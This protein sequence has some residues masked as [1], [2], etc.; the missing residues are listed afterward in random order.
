[1]AEVM[2]AENT[3]V[4]PGEHMSRYR[5]VAYGEQLARH[6]RQRPDRPA[7]SFGDRTLTYAELDTRVNRLCRTLG[8]LGVGPGDRVAVLMRNRPEVVESYF[9]AMR[10][11]AITVPVN[12]R[13]TAAEVRYILSDSGA[14]VLVADGEAA[15]VAHACLSGA[16]GEPGADLT[17][18][19]LAGGRPP[20]V[21]PVAVGYEEALD[22]DGSPVHVPVGDHDPAFIMYTS[23]TTGRPKGA[24]LTHLNLMMNSLNCLLVQGVTDDTEVY[25]SG[26]PL[27]HIGGLNGILIYMTVGGRSIVTASGDFSAAEA[28][29]EMARERVTACY[30]VPTQ[31]KEICRLP[32]IGGRDL[33]LRRISWGASVAPPAVLEAM[34]RTFPGIPNFNMFGQTEMSSVTCVLRGDDALRKTGSIGRPVP[35]LEVRLLGRDGTEVGPGEVGE[36]VYRG[37]TVMRGYWNAPEATREAFRGGWFHSGDLCVVDDDGFYRVVDRA[38]D[39]IISGGENIYCAEVEAAIETHPKVSDVAVVGARHPRWVETPV[40]FVVPADP[41]DPPTEQEIIAHCRERLAS[42]KK[43][44]RVI[45]AASLPRTATGKVQKFLLRQRVGTGQD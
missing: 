16:E 20:D 28:M 13:M 19:L 33:A 32:D 31:W 17:A 21:G 14:K 40:A 9:A 5:G 8:S 26:L 43:P 10:L 27:F 6:A 1:M 45:L 24:V 3:P 34:A 12:F 4:G 39:M 11:G 30:F 36:I 44:T 15:A 7:L 2:G 37:P 35:N 42:Y 25:Y 29:A 22:P 38:K 41:A 18:V 23:G